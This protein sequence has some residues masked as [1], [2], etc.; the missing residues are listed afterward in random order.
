[1]AG[2]LW[3]FLAAKHEQGRLPR[4]RLDIVGGYRRGKGLS[5][6]VDIL[7]SPTEQEETD[8][9]LPAILAHFQATGAIVD[10]L[11]Y[12]E[13]QS[14]RRRPAAPQSDPAAIDRLDKCLCIFREAPDMPLRRLDLIVAPRSQFAFALLGWSGS[15]QFER[16]IRL[17]AQ[18]ERGMQLASHALID[19]SGK[20][21]PAEREQDIFVALGLEYVPPEYRNC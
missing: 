6:D 11:S 4:C 7:I 17:F 12:S 18:R 9:I 21:V 3:Q 14:R 2:D 5:G 15:R 20:C 16:S 10:V 1:M 19:A 8:G 13:G